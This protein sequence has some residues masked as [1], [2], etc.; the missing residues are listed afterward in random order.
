MKIQ[1]IK[2]VKHLELC[3]VRNQ[4]QTVSVLTSLSWEGTRGRAKMWAGVIRAQETSTVLRRGL[5][6]EVRETVPRAHV[7]GCE[8]GIGEP[9]WL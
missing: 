8:V 1:V 4:Y 7:G 2:N 6:P 5:R 3:L 9:G